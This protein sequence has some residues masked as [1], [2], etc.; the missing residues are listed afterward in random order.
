MSSKMVSAEAV[1]SPEALMIRCSLMWSAYWDLWTR[2]F[3]VA[4]RSARGVAVS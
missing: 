3:S 2:R 4:D 1:T